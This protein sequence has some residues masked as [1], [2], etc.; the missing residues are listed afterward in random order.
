MRPAQTCA[1]LV[2]SGLALMP[3]AAPSGAMMAA[4]NCGSEHIYRITGSIMA[5]GIT[6]RQARRVFQAV[7]TA[8]PRWPAD[9]NSTP[10]SHWSRPFGVRTPIGQFTC[11]YK[12]YGLAGS[13][14]SIRCTRGHGNTSWNTIHD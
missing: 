6:C 9:V 2:A 10:Y 1:A 14:H 3:G 7:E 13:E 5:I 11:R 8:R 4:R 12:P